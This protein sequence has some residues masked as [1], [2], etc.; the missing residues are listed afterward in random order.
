MISK[1]NLKKIKEFNSVGLTAE[2]SLF[3]AVEKDLYKLN[4]YEKLEEICENVANSHTIYFKDYYG[5]VLK[6]DTHNCTAFYNFNTRTINICKKSTRV[7]K[8]F[9]IDDYG[10]EWWEAKEELAKYGTPG[11]SIEI[12]KKVDK[13]DPRDFCPSN[14][15]CDDCSWSGPCIRHPGN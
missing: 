5:K 2:S 13:V 10:K 15:S 9:Q 11:E 12:V 3:E 14:F 4:K 6:I 1:E 7:I 8:S